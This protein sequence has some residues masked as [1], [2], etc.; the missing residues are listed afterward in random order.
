MKR[1]TKHASEIK[2]KKASQNLVDYWEQA[3]M[4]KVL[5]TIDTQCPVEFDPGGDGF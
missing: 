4:S 5:A 3:K 2:P 1:P